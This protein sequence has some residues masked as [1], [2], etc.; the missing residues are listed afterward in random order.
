MYCTNCGSEIPDDAKFCTFCGATTEYSTSRQIPRA[1]PT[2]L[3]PT[4]SPIPLDSKP[5]SSSASTGIIAAICV[6]LIIGIVFIYFGTTSLAIMPSPAIT[7]LV[8][9]A[10]IILCI[11]CS[12]CGGCSHRR[13]RG[14]VGYVGGGDC[15]GCDCSGCD[16]DCSGCDC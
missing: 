4:P 12:V 8:I 6:V 7:M 15:S 16:C 9:G 13:R 5:K 11:G 1:Q 2:Q 3:T 14:G 10:I